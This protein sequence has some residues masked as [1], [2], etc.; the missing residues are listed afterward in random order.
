MSIKDT[1]FVLTDSEP[2]DGSDE[3]VIEGTLDEVAEYLDDLFVMSLWRESD[4]KKAQ[5]IRKRMEKFEW[6]GAM[7]TT[8][9]SF[10]VSVREKAPQ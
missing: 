7:F 2:D 9:L 8:L 1:I 10:G 4:Q 3:F 5:R 6:T